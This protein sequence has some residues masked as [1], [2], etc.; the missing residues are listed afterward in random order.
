MG[1]RDLLRER[2][3]ASQALGSFLGTGWSFPPRFGPGG[4]EVATVTGVADIHE[5]LQI[6]LS[7]RLGERVMREKFGCNLDEVMFDEVSQELVNRVTSQVNDA[8]LY[9]EPR[10][11]LLALDVSRDSDEAGL[12][13]IRLDYQVRA[14]NSRFNMVFPFYIDE[15]T[16]P[17]P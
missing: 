5:S 10:V 8:I 7:T 11:D 13:L 16:V 15:A 14:T 2:M 17:L 6:L 3:R 9:H 1:D 12:L 4:A